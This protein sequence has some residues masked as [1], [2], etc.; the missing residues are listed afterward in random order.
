VGRTLGWVSDISQNGSTLLE[1]IPS[2]A[3]AKAMAR[4]PVQRQSDSDSD[5]DS[6]N[7]DDSDSDPDFD[8]KV[9][10]GAVHGRV[11]ASAS[12]SSA[13]AVTVTVAAAAAAA[14]DADDDCDDNAAQ[15][16]QRRLQQD[17]ALARRL[18]ASPSLLAGRGVFV[19]WTECLGHVRRGA[20]HTLFPGVSRRADPRRAHGCRLRSGA[21][22][23][24]R[25]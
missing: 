10:S 1:K 14:D 12:T 2:E 17:E 19:S 22:P 8:T 15:A 13:A 6:D 23:T 16:A 11:R 9:G 4:E 24:R 25:T 21:W 3:E 5:S 7:S 20:W 18:Q